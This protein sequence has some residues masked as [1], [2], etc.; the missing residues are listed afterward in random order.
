[1]Q[2]KSDRQLMKRLFVICFIF[3]RNGDFIG[4]FILLI[5]VNFLNEVE[6]EEWGFEN[7][8]VNIRNQLLSLY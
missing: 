5:N 8:N 2:R 4:L 6:S 7:K 3:L 1:M